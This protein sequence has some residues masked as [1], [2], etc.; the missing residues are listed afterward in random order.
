MFCATQGLTEEAPNTTAACRAY[1]ATHTEFAHVPY[2][3]S[4]FPTADI[5]HS[6]FHALPKEID[7]PVRFLTVYDLIPLL[8]PQFIPVGVTRL[9]Q[10]T[11]SLIKPDDYFLCISHTTKGD[12]CRITGIDPARTI[13]THLAAD[14]GL[15]YPCTDRE[16][17][18]LVQKNMALIPLPTSLVCVHLNHEKILIM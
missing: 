4:D 17:L 9:Q 6:P 11:L 1:L 2:Y 3:E 15:F 13:V 10:Q 5:Y 16:A 18:T 7:V 12:L 8:F 14:T